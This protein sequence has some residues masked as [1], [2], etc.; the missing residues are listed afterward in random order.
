[1]YDSHGNTTTFT[2][3]TLGYDIADRHTTTTLGD[4]PV[5]TYVRNA[6]GTI[7]SRTEDTPTEPPVTIRF[8]ATWCAG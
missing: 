3:Q 7:V 5:I 1:M 2:D 8:S 4:G 6:T